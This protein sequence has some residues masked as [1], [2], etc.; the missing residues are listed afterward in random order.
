I[1]GTTAYRD[2][3]GPDLLAWAR[4][5]A[6]GAHRVPDRVR[7]EAAAATPGTYASR[8]F[9]GQY[10]RWVFETTVAALPPSVRVSTHAATVISTRHDA[11]RTVLELDD[12][13]T[14]ASD[15]VVLC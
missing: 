15:A 3:E 1:S 10:L 13:S 5:V 4:Q 2:G 6:A 14:I 12:G 8:S 11:D 7:Q 9:Y